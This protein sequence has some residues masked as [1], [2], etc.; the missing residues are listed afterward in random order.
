[1][2]TEIE[3]KLS[4]DPRAANAPLQHPAVKALRA[5]RTRTARVD[6]SYYDTDDSL[7]ADADVAL[8]VRRI[9]KRWVQTIKGPAE[10]A[11]GGGLFARAEYEW[12]L[13]RPALDYE[14]LA[15]TP[16]NKLIAKAIKRGG[17]ARRFTTDFERRTIP[18]GFP[19][20]TRAELCIDLGEIR[21]TQD[22]ETRR[23][24]IA[25]LEL[26]LEQ[27][28]E[29]NLFGLARQ[30]AEDLPI[31]VMTTSKADRGYA[32]LHGDRDVIGKPVRAETVRLAANASTE[33]TL[34]A[35]VRGC[36]GQIAA[37]APGLLA[38]DG[39]EWVHQMR[40]G[41]RR[42]RS[43]L[44][45]VTRLAPSGEL[46]RLVGDVRWLAQTLGVARDWDVFVG[47]TLPPLAKWFVQDRATAAGL[48]RLRSRA[49]MRRKLAR[50]IAREAVGS[51]RFQRI[52]LAGGYLCA[53]PR[54]A[55]EPPSE[56]AQDSDALGG[57]AADFAASLLARRHRK[58]EQSASALE[59]GSAEERHNVR[60]AAKRLRYVAE[61]FAP[62]FPRKRAK[63]Y[64]KALSAV[65]DVLGRLNDAATAQRVSSELGGTRTDAAAGAVR[66]WVAAQAAAL[67]PEIATA[68]RRFS[69]A[70]RFW[71]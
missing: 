42:L 50:T 54:F 3:L 35:L 20:G 61:F 18:L 17:L 24:P 27:G 47:E 23:A 68:W 69:R 56:A 38:D 22:G 28:N 32:L 7:L 36:L 30:L 8:R 31:A 64:L 29:A 63:P 52:L 13:A 34:A 25:E 40:I 71:A 65:Q 2:Q 15:A 44:R 37:N 57:R 51:A 9:G 43:C 16:W 12:P 58:L 21:A 46:R 70:K 33:E 48:K 53:A 41:T 4:V 39:V 62:L 45:L 19:D 26:E 1:V 11:T 59:S 66:G 60:I 67:E 14:R 49:Q 5:G 6:S 10:S 55:T